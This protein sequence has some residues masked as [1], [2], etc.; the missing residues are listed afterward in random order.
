MDRLQL[1]CK[2]VLLLVIVAGRRGHLLGAP[3]VLHLLHRGARHH[4]RG[5]D[6][7]RE[8]DPVQGRAVRSQLGR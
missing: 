6:Q 8:Q 5:R 1:N 4:D 7:R 3:R 2:V